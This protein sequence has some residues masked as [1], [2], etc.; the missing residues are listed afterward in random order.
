MGKKV[1][2][3]DDPVWQEESIPLPTGSQDALRRNRTM[4]LA[5]S[6]AAAAVIFAAGL[7]FWLSGSS[8]GPIQPTA[9]QTPKDEAMSWFEAINDKNL[10]AAQAHFV[11]TDRDMVDW[12]GGDTSSWSTFT[13]LRCTSL[14]GSTMSA[15]VY[16]SFKESASSS[17]GN[18]DSF[19]TISMQR[20]GSGP[21]LIDNY[22]Q[23]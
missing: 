19:W 16:C 15:V 13:N 6:A 2:S 17:E 10:S 7:T 18:P 23:G 9:T 21:W 8:G 20:A 1:G 4:T 22:G 11:P 12:G 3:I 14:K 5:L